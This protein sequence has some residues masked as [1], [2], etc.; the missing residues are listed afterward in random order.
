MIVTKREEIKSHLSQAVQHLGINSL[1]V[2][3][4]LDHR[5]AGSHGDFQI[6]EAD[7]GVGEVFARLFDGRRRQLSEVAVDGRLPDNGDAQR[8]R[9]IRPLSMD[10]NSQSQN[11]RKPAKRPRSH[12]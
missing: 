10:R 5:V 7:I 1:G 8:R 3:G 9:L 11:R 6:R 2:P 4:R 12:H